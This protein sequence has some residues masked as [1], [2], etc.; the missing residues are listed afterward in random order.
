M[1]RFE[2]SARLRLCGAAVAALLLTIAPMSADTP[3][4]AP[5]AGAPSA[6]AVPAPALSSAACIVAPAQARFDYPLPRTARRLAAGQPIKI[7][8]L[9]SSST[10]GLGASSPSASYPSRLA[11]ELTERFPGADVTVLNRGVNGE[12]APGMLARL[13]TSV[14]VENPDLVIWQLGT[15]WVLSDR[16]LDPRATAM[17]EG[18]ARLKAIGAD[19]VLIDPQFAPKVVAGWRAHE[20]LELCLHRQ[21]ARRRHRGRGNPPDR[22]RDGATRRTVIQWRNRDTHAAIR[23]KHSV[24]ALIS[25]S[26]MRGSLRSRVRF[27]KG[28]EK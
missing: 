15:N 22:D 2:L 6:Q 28:T 9:G 25:S 27:T 7:V 13:E 24:P 4:E 8:A 12:E 19:V 21:V 11:V 16:P 14:I 20:R 10:A 1:N 17:H 23:S 5:T 26:T 18:L 3:A